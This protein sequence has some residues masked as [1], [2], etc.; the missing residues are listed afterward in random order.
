MRNFG[1]DRM[2]KEQVLVEVPGCEKK[3]DISNLLNEVMYVGGGGIEKDFEEALAYVKNQAN[4]A[5]LD[6]PQYIDVEESG[7]DFFKNDYFHL[8]SLNKAIGGL[9][10]V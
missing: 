5:M 7:Q 6:L 10:M 9:E 3:L 4:E 1:K 8:N 2:F